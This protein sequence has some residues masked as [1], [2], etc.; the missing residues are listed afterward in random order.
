[1][2]ERSGPWLYAE[3]LP[4]GRDVVVEI[5]RVELGHV[6]DTSGKKS[7]RC[8]LWFKGKKRPLALNATNGKAVATMYGPMTEAWP[9]KLVALY[10]GETRDPTD[11]TKIDC[12]RIRNR[13]PRGAADTAPDQGGDADAAPGAV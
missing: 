5:E 13:P 10:V 3:H 2:T 4:K 6:T 12:V 8:V 1:M 9:K 7:N 11:G